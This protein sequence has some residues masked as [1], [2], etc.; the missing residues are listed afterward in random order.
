MPKDCWISPLHGD[1]KHSVL[2][3]TCT[4]IHDKIKA[5][6]IVDSPSSSSKLNKEFCRHH[7]GSLIILPCL[8]LYLRVDTVV[9]HSH[10][11]LQHHQAWHNPTEGK[12]QIQYWSLGEKVWFHDGE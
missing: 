12:S 3:N 2:Y 5:Y 11:F 1:F 7:T 6:L 10:L 4:P 8:A 9:P